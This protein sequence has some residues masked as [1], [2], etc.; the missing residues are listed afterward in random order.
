MCNISWGQKVSK[1]GP[2]S[3][4]KSMT[5]E[6]FLKK[7]FRIKYPQDW[8]LEEGRQGEERFILWSPASEEK[9]QF[10]AKVS[11][12]IQDLLG[13]GFTLDKYMKL[14]EYQIKSF[15]KDAI[16]IGRKR[17]K[18]NKIAYEKII[19]S[20]KKGIH[21]LK[22]E[23][24]YWVVENK[25]YVLTFTCEADQYDKYKTTAKK[26]LNGFEII[27]PKSRLKNPK[28]WQPTSA[29]DIKDYLHLA[30]TRTDSSLGVNPLV[31]LI[32]YNKFEM[33]W[34]GGD[35]AKYT[36][37]DDLTMTAI[38]S[39][40]DL[41]NT[42]TLWALGNHDY[43]NLKKVKQFTN[44]PPYYATHQD[45]ITIVVLDSQ[46]SLSNIVGAQKDFLNGI[47]DT[48]QTSSHLVLLHHK[49]IWMYGNSDLEPQ[50][51]LVSNGPL[52]ACFYCLNPNNFNSEIYPQLVRLQQSG[53]EV[54]CVGG[55]LGL[56]TAEFEFQT[57]DGIYFL[58]SGIDCEKSNN[59]ALWFRHD[60]KSRRLTWEFVLISD[61]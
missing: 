47:L 28:R 5:W 18:K 16:I 3:R 12:L 11:L 1:E 49:L 59:R 23:E 32:D 31:E 35:L 51:P 10:R 24:Y 58:A 42:K 45:G 55:D 27:H 38:D 40:F 25:A 52:D 26:I 57:P 46:D 54:L 13:D 20:G 19:Y 17:K 36:S 61:L 56:E 41:G 50:I 29:P 22:F 2:S 48:L 15:V 4:G 44:R 39:V 21:D 9:G 53:V 6:S 60:L 8:S 33:L 37:R 43:S 30:H 34:L 14:S 7:E